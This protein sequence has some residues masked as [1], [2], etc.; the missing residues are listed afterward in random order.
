MH[1]TKINIS[2][3]LPVWVGSTETSPTSNSVSSS[4]TLN[5]SSWRCTVTSSLTTLA[6]RGSSSVTRSERLEELV[7]LRVISP[8]SV[9]FEARKLGFYIWSILEHSILI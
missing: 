8:Y 3:P 9:L 6:I 4:K 2:S 1:P 7:I 5:R